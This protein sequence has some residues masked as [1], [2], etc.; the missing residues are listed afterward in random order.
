[1]PLWMI[2]NPHIAL[3]NHLLFSL[4]NT[5]SPKR[6]SA[7]CIHCFLLLTQRIGWE[8]SLAAKHHSN[9]SFWLS[10][11]RSP[12]TMGHPANSSW[13]HFNF[14]SSSLQSPPAACVKLL[15]SGKQ[16][17]A[18]MMA[19][20]A[21]PSHNNDLSTAGNILSLHDRPTPTP[22]GGQCRNISTDWGGSCSFT[23]TARPSFPAVKLSCMCFAKKVFAPQAVVK[24]VFR[25]ADILWWEK[26]KT[27]G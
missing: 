27:E 13:E 9:Q 8:T 11:T 1:M 25:R 20:V 4:C 3:C 19:R 14:C 17:S 16:F 2:V 21:E 6:L 24:T 5:T 12:H 10:L 22:T 23:L 7:W 26:G 18:L 15:F